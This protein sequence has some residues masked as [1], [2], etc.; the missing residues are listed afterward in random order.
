MTRLF[1]IQ[2]LEEVESKMQQ[3]NTH[4]ASEDDAEA[5]PHEEGKQ[6]KKTARSGEFSLFTL[7]LRDTLTSLNPPP[8]LAQTLHKISDKLLFSFGEGE[9]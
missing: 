5:H 7:G 6:P 1:S 2:K 9:G 4:H 3:K 8:L